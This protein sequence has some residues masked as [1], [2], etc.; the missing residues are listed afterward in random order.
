MKKI[1]TMI[2]DDEPLARDGIRVL[3][4]R[5]PEFE[6]VGECSDGRSALAAVNRQAPDL[7]FLDV[8]MPHLDGIQVLQK[9]T[10][11]P[12]PVVI[13]VTAFDRY[14]LQAFEHHALDYLLKPFDDDRFGATL[15]RVLRRFEQREAHRLSRRMMDLVREHGPDEEGAPTQDMET[16]PSFLRRLSIKSAGR[17]LFLDT[18]E[19]DWIEAADYYVKLH[20]GERSHLVRE[21]LNRLE[22]RLDPSAFMRIHRSTIVNLGRIKELRTQS[23]GDCTVCLADGTELRLSRGRRDLLAESL[24]NA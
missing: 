12:P 8:Q 10:L 6:L 4:E 22:Q 17:V 14:A 1:R 11:D 19:I 2:V 21:S 13:F 18:D 15:D 7:L 5:R 3:L 16:A 9:L 23:H 20:V 24:R